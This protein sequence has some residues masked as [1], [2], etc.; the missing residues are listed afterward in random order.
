[1]HNRNICV[2]YGL[3]IDLMDGSVHILKL[4]ES[5][6]ARKVYSVDS[7]LHRK[8]HIKLNSRGN[9][10]KREQEDESDRIAKWMN[11]CMSERIIVR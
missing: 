10:R 3:N 6:R 2:K 7:D 8:P 11:D 4:A 9:G 5:Q 1:M